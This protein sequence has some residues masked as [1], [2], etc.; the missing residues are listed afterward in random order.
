MWRSIRPWLDAAATLGCVGVP[1][2]PDC[3]RRTAGRGAGETA[4]R[5]FDTTPDVQQSLKLDVML[6]NHG[7]GL[8][9]D[10]AGWPRGETRWRFALRHSA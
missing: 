7:E 8:R 6:E 2:E 10:G 5:R 1:S 3:R 9:T 4:G